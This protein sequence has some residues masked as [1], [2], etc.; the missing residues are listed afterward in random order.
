[1]MTRQSVQPTDRMFA[2]GYGFSPFAKNMRKNIG[3]NVTKNLS[4]KYNQKFLDHAKKSATDEEMNEDL[5]Y[6]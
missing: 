1:M 6:F 3:R 5:S 4:G 2:K